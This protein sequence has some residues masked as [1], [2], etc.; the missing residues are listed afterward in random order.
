[1]AAKITLRAARPDDFDFAAA[2]Y[3]ESAKPLLVALDLW[4]E[5]RVRARFAEDFKPRSARVI[6]NAG[7]DI[8]WIQVS[9]T[10]QGFHLDQLHIVDGYRNQ[11]IGTRLVEALLDRARRTGR[12]VGLNVIRGNRAMYLYQR[13]GFHL[14]GEDEDKLR[15]RWESRRSRTKPLKGRTHASQKAR[16]AKS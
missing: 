6:R 1:M 2:L 10:D 11:G 4:N 3:L 8:G 15:M 16:T 9:E 7:L 13:L 14:V 12:P 5:E